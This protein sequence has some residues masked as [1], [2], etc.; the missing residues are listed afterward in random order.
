MRLLKLLVIGIS[1]SGLVACEEAGHHSFKDD[2]SNSPLVV[3]DSQ[4]LLDAY[5]NT[6]YAFGQSQGCV[7]CHQARISP[8]WLSTNLEQ[9]YSVARLRLD[10]NNPSVSSF[11]YYAGNNHCNNPICADPANVTVMQELLTQWAATEITVAG[12]ANQPTTG[13]PLANPSFVT[14]AMPIP[15]PLPTIF[16]ATPAVIRFQLSQLNPPVPALANAILEISIQSY[17]ASF[18]E[19]K[20]FNPRII[21]ATGPVRV[22]GMHV[23]IRQSAQ[24]GLGIE[25]V[26]QGDLWSG[27]NY[28]VPMSLVPSPL[29]NGPITS[30]SP[31]VA[32][33][34]AIQALSASDVLTIGFANIQ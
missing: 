24:T 18:S 6:V 29:P 20:V 28:N 11:A 8:N 5:Q 32:Q 23:Y 26:N 2:A 3:I 14:A 22:S 13:G 17:N 15:S 34:L 21:G 33:A 9:A 12:G 1:I 10:V 25:D 27:V 19:Y 16:Q 30:V 4:Q 7:N 31:I